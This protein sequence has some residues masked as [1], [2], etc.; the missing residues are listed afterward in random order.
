[1]KQRDIASIRND[2]IQLLIAASM[3]GGVTWIR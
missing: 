2:A 1:M 3:G